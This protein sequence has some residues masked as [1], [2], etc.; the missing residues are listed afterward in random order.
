MAALRQSSQRNVNLE[1]VGF[2]STGDS[3]ANPL[4]Q[5]GSVLGGSTGPSGACWGGTPVCVFPGRP[6]PS[7]SQDQRGLGD[8]M[9]WNPKEKCFLGGLNVRGNF[10][11]FQVSKTPQFPKGRHPRSQP[12]SAVVNTFNLHTPDS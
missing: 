9:L 6:S 5:A 3:H 11:F 8:L 12:R 2:T 7:L 10:R 4:S 1:I